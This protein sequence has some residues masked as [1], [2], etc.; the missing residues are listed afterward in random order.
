MT[1]LNDIRAI[2]GKLPGAVE[3]E[4]EQFSF[5]V[6]V[7]GKHKGFCWS[8][9]ERIDPKKP[10]VINESVLAVRVPSLS[11]KD[12]ILASGAAGVF[13]EPHYENYPAILIRLDE[14]AREDLEGY[15][16][17]AWQCT[18]PRSLTSGHAES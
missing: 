2:C 14:M 5:G 17:E 6:M 11:A 16:E 12:V 18:A 7:K 1:T 9:R 13:T 15:L 4:G 10:R 8:W 3:G